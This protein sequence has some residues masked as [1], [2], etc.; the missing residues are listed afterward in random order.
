MKSFAESAFANIQSWKAAE[1]IARKRGW[2][3]LLVEIRD[4]GAIEAAFKMAS[5]GHANAVLVFAA[6]V[7]ASSQRSSS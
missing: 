3:V 2:K 4:A 7:P 6:G 1:V 5:D